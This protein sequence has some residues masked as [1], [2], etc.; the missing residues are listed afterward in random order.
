MRVAFPEGALLLF[1]N[2]RQ[3]TT[4]LKLGEDV[5]PLIG[6]SREVATVIAGA[7]VGSDGGVPYYITT[8]GDGFPVQDDGG[9]PYVDFTGVPIALDPFGESGSTPGFPLPA[10]FIKLTNVT[11]ATLYNAALRVNVLREAMRPGPPVRELAVF[12]SGNRMVP[13]RQGIAPYSD[14]WTDVVSVT[15]SYIAM[16]TLSA[17]TD[18]LTLPL[19]LVDLLEAALAE[20]LAMAVPANEMNDRTRQTFVDERGAAEAAIKEAAAEI[21][22]SVTTSHVQ[23]N[24]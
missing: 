14:R 12:V 4:L 6:Q 19:Q 11:A 10:E 22:G 3:R 17:V 7:L 21:L 24:G 18:V 2:Q 13:I 1:L 23:F 20:R 16:Q 9:V 8:S 5:E 15:V